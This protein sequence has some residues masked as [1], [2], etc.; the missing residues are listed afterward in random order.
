MVAVHVVGGQKRNVNLDGARTMANLS[1]RVTVSPALTIQIRRSLSVTAQGGTDSLAVQ[2][3][4]QAEVWIVALA[5]YK[6]TS[7][8][9]NQ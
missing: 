9:E 6:T 5:A 8:T 1:H 4:T 7:G 2:V 3:V